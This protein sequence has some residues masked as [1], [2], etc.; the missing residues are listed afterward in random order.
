[1]QGQNNSSE[2][3]DQS[4][5]RME[6][7]IAHHEGTRQSLLDKLSQVAGEMTID[8]AAD[9]PTVLEAKMNIISRINELMN[10]SVMDRERVV[11]A[12][13]KK[14]DT[15]SGQKNAEIVAEFLRQM[16]TGVSLPSQSGEGPQPRDSQTEEA[17]DTTYRDKCDPIKEEELEENSMEPAEVGPDD[18]PADDDAS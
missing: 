10:S 11:K 8:P 17:L 12:R 9:K 1:M 13:L 18:A 7:I 15:E 3:V 5:K 4:I 2:Q 6:D 14:T 16:G